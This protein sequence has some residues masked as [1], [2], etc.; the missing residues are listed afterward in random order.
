M[1]NPDVGS[2]KSPWIVMPEA[3]FLEA[4]V[5]K[6]NGFYR[7]P[8]FLHLVHSKHRLFSRIHDMVIYANMV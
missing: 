4:E 5:G 7:G 8:Q 1:N 3:T 2:E 6:T